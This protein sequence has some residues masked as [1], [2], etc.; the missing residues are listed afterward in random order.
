MGYDSDANN[1]FVALGQSNPTVFTDSTINLILSLSNTNDGNIKQVT[2]GLKLAGGGTSDFVTI[3]SGNTVIVDTSGNTIAGGTGNTT[4]IGGTSNIL[5]SSLVV[6]VDPAKVLLPTTGAVS[7]TVTNGGKD[8]TVHLPGGTGIVLKTSS[9]LTTDTL[10]TA[11]N[12][13]AKDI[14]GDHPTTATTAEVDQ[15][16][17]AVQQLVAGNSKYAGVS[18]TYIDFMHLH[19]ATLT[20][21][22]SADHPQSYALLDSSGNY[23]GVDSLV[24][25]NE[26]SFSPASSG[27]ADVF[28]LALGNALGQTVVLSNV[29]AAALAGAGTVRVDDNTPIRIT[30]DTAAQ[31]ITGGGGNDTLIGSGNDTLTGGAGNDIFGIS[32]PGHY[33]VTDFQKAGDSLYVHL[34]GVT[35]FAQLSAKVTSVV[36]TAGSVTYNLGADTSITLVGVTAADLTAGMI[37]FT[38]S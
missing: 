6:Q 11:V 5:L 27:N 33:T 32:G 13:I 10:S 21:T 35:N 26:I 20:L 8:L 22:D 29:S 38:L 14:L 34:D 37:K 3:G 36:T 31:N 2:G 16:K 1:V 15:I 4:I 23:Q 28:V 24:G 7:G 17:L 9:S 19:N 18:L 12:S 25:A 30:S